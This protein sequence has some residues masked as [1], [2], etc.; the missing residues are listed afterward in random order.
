MA[1][2]YWLA[3]DLVNIKKFS[4]V[5]GTQ[6]I[7]YLG[8]ATPGSAETDPKWFIK[9]LTYG[10]DGFV[11]DELFAEGNALFDKLWALRATYTYK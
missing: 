5:A 8:Y 11:T 4:K 1:W 7:E 6:N 9:K 3:G 10:A 2:Q